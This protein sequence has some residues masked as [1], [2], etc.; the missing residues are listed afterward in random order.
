M[1]YTRAMTNPAIPIEE[2]LLQADAAGVRLEIV[3]GL[4]VWEAQPMYFHQ[5]EVDRIRASIQTR[6]ANIDCGCHHLGDVY[7]RFPDGSLKRPDIAILCQQPDPSEYFK[8]ITVIPEAVV[9]II[10]EG[11]EDKDLKLAPGFYLGQGVK[12]VLIFDPRAKVIW[13]H[14][15]DGVERLNSPAKISLECGCKC[16]I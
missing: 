12:D 10:S 2:L 9:E 3:S 1:N 7:F 6:D 5:L 4:P 13:H 15:A 14:R 8:P 11:Y 16:E